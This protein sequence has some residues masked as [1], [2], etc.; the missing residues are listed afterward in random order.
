MNDTQIKT[1][2]WYKEHSTKFNEIE[3]KITLKDGTL[4]IV[5]KTHV[6]IMGKRG[7]LTNIE[8]R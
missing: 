1:L 8:I 3:F 7:G 2:N 4:K 6:Y 5:T